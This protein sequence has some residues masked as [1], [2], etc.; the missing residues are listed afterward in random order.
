M[1][2][3]LG[4]S[5]VASSI[6]AST[7]CAGAYKWT[8][9]DTTNNLSGGAG[10]SISGSFTYDKGADKVSDINVTA[11][12]GGTTYTIDKAGRMDDGFLRLV[13]AHTPGTGHGFYINKSALGSGGDVTLADI[14]FAV[15]DCLS[16]PG[17]IC[18]NI[19]TDYNA[20]AGKK[21]RATA[22][23]KLMASMQSLGKSHLSG[24]ST[25]LDGYSGSDSD[26][27]AF[28]AALANY[29]GEAQA[30]QVEQSMSNIAASASAVNSQVVTAMSNVVSNR[31]SGPVGK[32]SGDTLFVDNN[33]WVK[34]FGNKAKQKDKDGKSGFD[35]KSHGIA[36]GIDGEYSS[37]KRAGISFFYTKTDVDTNNVSQ[38]NSIDSYSLIGYGSQPIIDKSTN[39]YYQLGGVV[40]KNSSSR[41]IQAISKRAKADYKTYAAFADI[42]VVRD[43]KLNDDFTISPELG[44]TLS[45]FKSSDYSENGAGGMNLTTS[46]F[47]SYAFIATLGSGITYSY[48]KYTN[49]TS[50]VAINYDFIDDKNETYSSLQ[51]GGN[52]FASEGLKNSPLGYEFGLGVV[53]GITDAISLD[54]NYDFSGKDAS[55]TN[56]AI[57]A[58]VTWNF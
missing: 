53:R 35:S 40:N 32:N 30:R 27:S 20:V 12:L 7:L 36:V 29:T 55:Y 9:V 26:I 49:F 45:Y 47:D 16:V 24:V 56:H 3:R 38:S 31:Q 33:F 28:K 22:I 48:D 54:I 18:V 57:A 50:R 37:S 2:K 44:S 51:G 14:T 5:L 11:I 8:F 10:N 43:Y 13:S 4:I 6:V 39:L 52:S 17:S 21:I 46:S 1:I 42:K 34:A 41:D 25:V 58:K 15:G 19:D 23:A